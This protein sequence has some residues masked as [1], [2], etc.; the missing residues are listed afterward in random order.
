LVRRAVEE[1]STVRPKPVTV[2]VATAVLLCACADDPHTT[3]TALGGTALGAL[4]GA[5]ISNN[6]GAH[7][8][9]SGALIGAAAVGLI[10]VAKGR[11]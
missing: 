5:V 6:T 11:A 3:N 10:G 2:L 1:S 9:A 4:A 8:A 7:N